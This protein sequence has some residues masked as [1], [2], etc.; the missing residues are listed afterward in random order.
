[1]TD[2]A[3][4][5]HNMKIVNAF[6]EERNTGLKTCEIIFNEGDTIE[7]FLIKK[8]DI[9]FQYSVVKIPSNN[10]RLLHELEDIG[11]KFIETQFCISVDTCEIDSFNK[12]WDRI[13]ENTDIERIKDPD[14]LEFLLV[15]IR[16]GMFKS[17]RISLDEKF[18]EK[19]S[20]LR[21]TNWIKDIF[22][23]ESYE[24]YFLLKHSKR[25]GFFVINRVSAREM[26][27]TIAGIFNDHKGRGLSVALI[28]CY[29][30]LALI[31]NAKSVITSFSSN[32]LQMLNTFTRTVAFKTTSVYYVLRKVTV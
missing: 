7:D 8:T 23:D 24:I 9:E 2:G 1:M 32:N 5:C 13:I 18:G 25:A 4:A 21:Y 29:L 27:S 12:K 20:S 6:W 31:N 16:E 3:K 14:D 26:K 22:N 10:L 11:Y 15:K 28:Y 17:D 30:K 19:Y